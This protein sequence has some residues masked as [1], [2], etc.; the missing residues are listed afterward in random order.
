MI[1]IMKIKTNRS[2]VSVHNN[3]ITNI[4][5]GAVCELLDSQHGISNIIFKDMTIKVPV[6]FYE[7]VDNSVVEEMDPIEA[8][9][10]ESIK[11]QIISLEKEIYCQ[12]TQLSQLTTN[13]ARK[14]KQYEIDILEAKLYALQED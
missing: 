12:K 6:S 10:L 3:I 1:Q 5:E 2:F 9:Y 13:V 4:H 11:P 14:Y 8:A 7:E